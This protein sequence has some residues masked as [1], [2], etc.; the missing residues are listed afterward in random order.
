MFDNDT[1]GN[2]PFMTNS[3]ICKE[4]G[5]IYYITT[6][7]STVYEDG[8]CWACHLKK[9]EESLNLYYTSS[10]KPIYY[11]EE[12]FKT[13]RNAQNRIMFFKFEEMHYMWYYLNDGEV[14]N[15]TEREIHIT[16][17]FDVFLKSLMDFIK[18]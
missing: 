4:C 7:P 6:L 11:L 2:A 8:L 18:E 17:S 5:S 16:Q 3:K 13:Y 12:N 9:I 15:I 1:T 14:D 10:T